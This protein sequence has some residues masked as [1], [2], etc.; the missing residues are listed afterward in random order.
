M[1]YLLPFFAVLFLFFSIAEADEKRFNIPAADSP[2]KGPAD[3]SVTIVEFLD[4][5]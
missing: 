2:S 5:Q 4:F 3:A 1:K